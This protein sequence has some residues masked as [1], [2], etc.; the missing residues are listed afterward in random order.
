M[1]GY[2][3]TLIKKL[4]E[5][6]YIHDRWSP[7]G[8]IWNWRRPVENG[9]I[10]TI[11][12]SMLAELQN[13]TLTD[14]LDSW[15]WQIGKDGVYTVGD[16][17]RHIDD[18]ILPSIDVPTIWNKNLPRKV[19]VFIWRLR[20]DRLPNRFNMSRCSL[21]IDSIVC[22]IGLHGSSRCKVGTLAMI[23]SLKKPCIVGFM[24]PINST[25]PPTPPLHHHSP[26]PTSSSM[27]VTPSTPKPTTTKPL[28]HQ[29]PL[30]L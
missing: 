15:L 7:N 25:P 17:H 30:L 2:E 9:R 3:L 4:H 28:Y 6:C 19:N 29:M 20:L 21:D 11:F 13:V 26:P 18:H 10:C 16:T 12:S 5:D 24:K 1:R 8:W 27:I 23:K 22:P 14:N